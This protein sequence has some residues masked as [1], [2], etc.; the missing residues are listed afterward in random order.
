MSKTRNRRSRSSLQD[1]PLR[2]DGGDGY[3]GE[4]PAL[5]EPEDPQGN[6]PS[7]LA[8]TKARGYENGDYEEPCT[9]WVDEAA[10][11]RGEV[12]AELARLR[13]LRTVRSRSG[14]WPT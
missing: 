1:C 7:G 13:A 3:F 8:E 11:L 5:K 12:E 4:I 2:G 10:L 9:W 14:H 6:I